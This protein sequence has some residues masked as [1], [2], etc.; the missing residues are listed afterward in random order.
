MVHSGA[1]Q[2]GDEL[3]H[4]LPVSVRGHRLVCVEDR[5]LALRFLGHEVVERAEDRGAADACG[6]EQQRGLGVFDDEVAVG[7]GASD[8]V[9]FEDVAVDEVRYLTRG[10]ACL[11]AAGFGLDRH[12]PGLM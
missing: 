5:D 11:D 9:P 6:D 12:G 2:L 8:R 3:S 10:D 1:R 4:I 7:Q